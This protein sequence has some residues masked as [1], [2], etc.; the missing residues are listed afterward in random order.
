MAPKP[1]RKREATMSEYPDSA[2]GGCLCGTVRYQATA[3][4]DY[5]AYCHCNSCRK[6]T[7]AP[8]VAYATYAEKDVQYT[9]G[10]RRV[11]ASS[12]GVSRTFCGDC[13]TP[14]SYEAEWNG[15]IVIG[16]FI[17]TLDEPDNFPPQKHVAHGDRIS[18]FDAADALPRFLGFPG[19]ASS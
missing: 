4:P 1:S 7:G 12:P 10:K 19:G 2:A 5:V 8:V 17:S 14:I 3:E 9:K 16:F 13:G 15:D 18:W 6:A 11:F